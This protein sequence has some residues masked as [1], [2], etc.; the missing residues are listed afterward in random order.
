VRAIAGT[1]TDDAVLTSADQRLAVEQQNG[2]GAGVVDQ[3]LGHHGA[4]VDPLMWMWP[5]ERGPHM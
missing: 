2:L 4:T 1:R 5:S 3:Q